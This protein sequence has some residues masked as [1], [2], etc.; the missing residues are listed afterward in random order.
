MCNLWWVSGESWAPRTNSGFQRSHPVGIW[1]HQWAPWEF[2][3]QPSI[4]FI[5]SKA[6][7]YINLVV[8]NHFLQ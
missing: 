3:L 6:I 4:F 5:N 8:H 7:N 1:G 2:A